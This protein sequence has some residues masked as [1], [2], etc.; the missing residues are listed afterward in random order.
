MVSI[1]TFALP[2]F[3]S[4]YLL[5]MSALTKTIKRS[6]TLL[7]FIFITMSNIQSQEKDTLVVVETK[8]GAIKLKLYNDTPF[9]KANFLKLVNE[10][11]YKDLLF[12]RVIEDF[13]VQGGDPQSRAA[14]DSSSLGAGDLKYTIPA[15]IKM[16]QHFHKKGALAAA[17]TGDDVNPNRESSAMQFYIVTGK[18][19]S[20]KDLTKIEQQRQEKA[21]QKLYNEW[22]ITNKAAIKEFY[23]SGDRDGLAAF[24]QGLY[25]KAQEEAK[26]D[27]AN[28]FSPQ[29]REAYTT[30][31]G[32]PSLDGAYTV[33]GEVI[34]GIE[35][36]EKIGKVKTNDQDRPVENIKMDVKTV[37]E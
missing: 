37:V 16:P 11:A 32:A 13:M 7:L 33:F 35:V 19:Y 28:V 6:A 5:A 34:E 14:A 18:K 26:T 30:V 29:Q 8:F 12:H 4:L 17:R 24:R 2:I 1:R 3:N 20:D 27:V 25:A 31:G 10:G 23:S 9:H 21:V 15:E 22:Q 36:L